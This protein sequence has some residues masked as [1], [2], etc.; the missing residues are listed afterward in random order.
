MGVCQKCGCDKDGFIEE[1]KRLQARERRPLA[2]PSTAL[3]DA[4]DEA[5]DMVCPFCGDTDYDRIGLKHHLQHTCDKWDAIP[6]VDFVRTRETSN[7]SLE[8]LARK[9]G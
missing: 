8:P 3:L 5:G 7:A 9:D 2:I 4:W 6:P 1:I